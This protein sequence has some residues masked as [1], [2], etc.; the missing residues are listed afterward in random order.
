MRTLSPSFRLFLGA[1]FLLSFAGP[2]L[3]APTVSLTA[4]PSTG[5]GSADV[6]L[7]W[8]STAAASCVASGA[9]SDAKAL[10]G[11]QVVSAVTA[12][13][14]FTLTCTEGSASA[15]LTWTPPTQN[16]DGSALTNLASY[17]IYHAATSSGVATATPTT[18]T[19]PATTYTVTGLA[20]G[21]RHFGIKAVNAAGI[22]SDM[23]NLASK[24]IVL[25]SA[26]TSA[27]VTI[28]TK[29]NPPTI[30]AV[31]TVAKVLTRWGLGL[32]VGTVALGTPCGELKR[33][34][35]RADWHVVEASA[36]Q[37]NKRGQ[38]LPADAVIVAKCAAA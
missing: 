9:W 31:E 37:F 23:S 26:A 7:T 35:R 33:D 22:E 5:V 8:S 17:K 11:T 25:A 38:K 28:S 16:T 4:S 13:S 20:A 29:P 19:A 12:T 21:T 34:T 30:V 24:A 32:K 1:L 6:T 2:L 10:T 18:V 3:A 27:T 36:V 14:T 15:V